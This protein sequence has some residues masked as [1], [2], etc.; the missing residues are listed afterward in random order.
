MAII[1][2]GIL[3]FENW[4]RLSIVTHIQQML[5]DILWAEKFLKNFLRIG[6]KFVFADQTGVFEDSFFEILFTMSIVNFLFFG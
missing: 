2:I 4:M 5:I 6:R 1:Q 3:G